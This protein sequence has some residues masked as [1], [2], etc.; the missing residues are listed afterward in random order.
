MLDKLKS[1]FYSKMSIFLVI[2]LIFGLLAIYGLR[3][4]YSK[5][6]ELRTA[7]NVADQQ[8]GDVEK[9]LQDLRKYVISHMNT[10]LTSGSNSIK[11]PIQ[12][13]YRY[14]RLQTTEAERVKAYNTK[15]N[16]DGTTICTRQY[17]DPGYNPPR[18]QCL[19]DYVAKNSITDGGVP[20]SLYK[21]DFISPKWSP[22]LAGYSLI[23]SFTSL[24]IFF[25][26]YILSA[27]KKRLL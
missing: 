20:D 5:M 11:P 7:V 9:A 25:G 23:I 16:N 15:V 8:N 2:G 27:I 1:L 24:L 21:F 12:L 17:P 4:N 19:Q 10:N 3:H 22:D 26:S 14:E 18:V 6:N 13:K